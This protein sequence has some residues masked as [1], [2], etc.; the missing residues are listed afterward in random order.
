M[1]TLTPEESRELFRL[2]GAARE[3]ALSHWFGRTKVS[4]GRALQFLE[5]G[6]HYQ[7][8]AGQNLLTVLSNGDLCPCRRMPIRVGNVTEE[9][10]SRLYFESPV[11]LSLRDRSRVASG[12]GACPFEP[13]CRGGLRCLAYAVTGDPFR[14]DPGCW[15]ADVLPETALADGGD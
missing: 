8:K 10:L 13:Q 12:C 11:L 14:A 6:R 3:E 2:M 5:G 1:A 15:L 7:C 9:S 4:M